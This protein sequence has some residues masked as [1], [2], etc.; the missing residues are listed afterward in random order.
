MDK[1]CKIKS[2]YDKVQIFEM[3]GAYETDKAYTEKGK[4]DS[5]LLLQPIQ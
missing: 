2:S 5:L 1:N 4:A 3:D